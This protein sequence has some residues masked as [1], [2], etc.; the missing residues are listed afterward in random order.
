MP[1]S[2]WRKARRLGQGCRGGAHA[3]SSVARFVCHN[4]TTTNNDTTTTTTNNNNTAN[5]FNTNA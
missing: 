2:L 4:D 5:N 3:F 1:T